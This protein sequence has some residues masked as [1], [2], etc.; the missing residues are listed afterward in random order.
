[1]KKTKLFK[2]KTTLNAR[3]Y[4]PRQKSARQKGYDSAWQK[5]RFRFLHHNPNCYRCNA[6]S[7]VVDHLI[8]HK[9]SD[10]LFKKLDNHIP[11][12]TRCHNYLTA[13]YDK[14]A[15]PKTKEKLQDIAK[16]RSDNNVT[17]RVKVLP[18]YE[19]KKRR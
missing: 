12:C 16:Y 19:S 15:E 4:R 11:L 7:K 10:M 6:P 1:M 3:R 9:G 2:K 17:S 8:P 5:Y 18:S 13:K 14:Y